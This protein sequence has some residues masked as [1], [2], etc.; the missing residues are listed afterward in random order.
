VSN[1][2]LNSL[3]GATVH[4]SQQNQSTL[5]NGGPRLKERGENKL[6]KAGNSKSK[7][8]CVHVSTTQYDKVL[9]F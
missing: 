3:I 7:A 1:K 9:Q 8:Q 2:T 4:Q 5:C 6:A